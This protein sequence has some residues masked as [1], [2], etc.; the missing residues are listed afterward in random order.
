[1]ISMARSPHTK[2]TIPS[3]VN[4]HCLPL[5][6][7]SNLLITALALFTLLFPPPS[8]APGFQPTH[9]IPLFRAT[10]LHSIHTSLSMQLCHMHIRRAVPHRS[11]L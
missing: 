8:Q 9:I 2:Y 3:Y 5:L 11:N 10:H 4:Q 7:H 1:M 6:N